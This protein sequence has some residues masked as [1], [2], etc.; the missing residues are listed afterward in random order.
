[1]LPSAI[2]IS[3]PRGSKPGYPGLSPKPPRMGE[4]ASKL[5]ASNFYPSTIDP[6]K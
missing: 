3:E 5:P 4:G 1:M 2:A 6:E